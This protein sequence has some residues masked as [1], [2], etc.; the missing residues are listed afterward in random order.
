[1][2]NALFKRLNSQEKEAFLNL[3]REKKIQKGQ[4]IKQE[5]TN[6]ENAFFLKEGELLVKKNTSDDMMEIATV[7]TEDV[8]FSI[9]CLVDGGKS[10]TSVSAKKDSI[11]LEITQKDF[12]AFCERN[13]ETGVKI[14]KNATI[15][16]AKFL[17][18]SDEKNAEMYK[19]L[20]EV[21]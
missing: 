15:M 2:D 10:T 16:L 8:C 1:M 5:K 6:T 17:R 13:P 18:K 20:E 4:I 7:S 3:F 19:T 14:L 9:T 11:I 21:L 12:F